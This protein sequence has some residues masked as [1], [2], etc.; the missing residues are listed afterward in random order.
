MATSLS[1]IFLLL[2]LSGPC[3]DGNI[4]GEERPV[5]VEVDGFTELNHIVNPDG[6]FRFSQIIIWE[7]DN[8]LYTHVIRGWISDNTTYDKSKED[9]ERDLNSLIEYCNK[10]LKIKPPLKKWPQDWPIP[11][12]RT[13]WIGR[14]SNRIKIYET[15]CDLILSSNHIT[16]HYKTIYRTKSFRESQ[17]I[18]TESDFTGD[19]ELE[20]RNILAV[21]RRKGIQMIR[22]DLLNNFESPNNKN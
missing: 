9:F 4:L 2:T 10:T 12:N 6:S 18:I 19:I 5:I 14:D 21:E 8:S 11:I 20:N 7:W 15:H 13:K 17:T 22:R 16:T 3:L 1:T